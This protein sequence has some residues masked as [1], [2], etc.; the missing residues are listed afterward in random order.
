VTTRGLVRRERAHDLQRPP[1]GRLGDVEDVHLGQYAPR[2]ESTTGSVAMRISMSRAS[3]HP[4][5][6]W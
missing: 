2:P 1:R 4:A 5:T 6:Y 3:D